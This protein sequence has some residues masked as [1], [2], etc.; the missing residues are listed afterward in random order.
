[1][2][3]DESDKS[4][5]DQEE[6]EEGE[7][8]L[9]NAN[10]TSESEN[11]ENEQENKLR[12][13]FKQ[14]TFFKSK[15]KKKSTQLKSQSMEVASSLEFSFKTYTESLKLERI[16]KFIKTDDWDVLTDNDLIMKYLN[17]IQVSNE[18]LSSAENPSEI[19]LKRVMQHALQCRANKR[20]ILIPQI[21]MNGKVKEKDNHSLWYSDFQQWKFTQTGHIYNQFF[22]K[23][24]LTL[25]VS[26]SFKLDIFVKQTNQH[27]DQNYPGQAEPAVRL[28]GFAVV[29]GTRKTSPDQLN[30]VEHQHW[31]YNKF[32]NIYSKSLNNKQM[33]LTD[34]NIL[35]HDLNVLSNNN[36]LEKYELTFQDEEN[37]SIYSLDE[38]SLVLIDAFDEASFVSQD[39]DGK[40]K[41]KLGKELP[42]SQ[43]WAIKQ[44]SFLAKSNREW[45]LSKLAN[46]KWNK[47]TY[48]WPVD[49]NEELISN[50]SW[51]L[52]GFLIS[53]API[54]RTLEEPVDDSGRSR[55]KVIRNGCIDLSTACILSRMEVKNLV[56]EYKENL[57]KDSKNYVHCTGLTYSKLEFNAF[58]DACTN[59]LGLRS[60]ARR[61]FDEN[62]EEHT[63]LN[64]LDHDQ[65][66]YISQ[67]EAWIHPKTVKEEQERKC[68]L[69]YLAEDLNK[70]AYFMRYKKCSNFVLEVC[71]SSFQE[72]TKLTLSP[73]CLSPSQIERIKQGESIQHVIELEEVVDESVDDN[74]NK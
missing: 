28:T 36:F 7:D 54:L 9:I 34:L 50:F 52:S 51:P 27:T 65:L 71:K 68:L 64:K 48:T 10:V 1:M 25:D 66:V 63:D 62:G 16:D 59:A 57:I 69:N 12:N 5:E 33:V 18:Y 53:G 47:L 17:E 58:L 40:L 67:G 74:K 55:L 56:K 4:E 14:K 38:L 22:T 61:L 37:S 29:L 13:F 32:G 35:K 73:C 44:D 45:R 60:A 46:S 70:I 15:K 30:S 31:H 6:E 8:S 39:V 3:D 43:R 21:A 19:N 42:K 41:S 72:G 20:I 23:L 26:I 2:P 24:C 11:D 49:E